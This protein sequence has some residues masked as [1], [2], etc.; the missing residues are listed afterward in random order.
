MFLVYATKPLLGKV[1]FPHMRSDDGSSMERIKGYLEQ[2]ISIDTWTY[3]INDLE[4]CRYVI[5]SSAFFALI[6]GFA[7]MV[8]MKMCVGFLTWLAIG[9][10]YISL[11]GLVYFVYDLGV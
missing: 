5:L 8:I 2:Y 4:V 10:I 6:I 3:I 9:L 1:C 11:T 7:W